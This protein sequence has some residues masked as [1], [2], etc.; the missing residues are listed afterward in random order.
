MDEGLTSDGFLGGRLTV[1]QPRLGYRAAT[2]PVLLAAAVPARAGDSVLEL[3]C[4][5]GVASLC[6]LSRVP[7]LAA[8]G[9]ELQPLY[10]D[11]ARRNALANDLPLTV[12]TADMRDGALRDRRYD[13]VMANPPYFRAGAGT[14]ARDAG[15]ETAF[16]EDLP[17]P[18]WIDIA[19]RRTRDGGTVTLIHLAERLGDIL[20]ALTP[21]AGAVTLLPVAP[22]AG[23][24][25]TRVILRAK[26]GSRAPLT[27]LAPLVLHQGAD[28]LADGD[29]YADAARA[30]L[31]QGQALADFG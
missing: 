25:A 8:T 13:H 9:V 26:K 21:R 6:L 2:D 1:L 29:D 5:V 11:L 23:R 10:A 31:R 18:D 7:G 27:L 30:V 22:R 16:R 24:A 17:L 14:A 12:I 20:Q 15:R 3:G 4:G 28:H 19:L